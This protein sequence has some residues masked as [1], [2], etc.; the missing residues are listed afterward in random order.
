M[1][2]S[3]HLQWCKERALE[4]IDSGDI[5]GAYASMTSDLKKHPETE[6]HTAIML[7]MM[8]M[9]GGHLNTPNEM[10]KF[11]EGFN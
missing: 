4:Y 7:G 2:R 9:L 11:I 3:E 10:R 1:T 5:S 6:G 8:L